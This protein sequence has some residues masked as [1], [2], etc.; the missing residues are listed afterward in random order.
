MNTT[1]TFAQ[2]WH[3]ITSE[4]SDTQSFWLSLFRDVLYIPFPEQYIQ[5]EKRVELSHMS[6]IDAYI[7]ST[8]III[9]QKSPGVNL[10]ESYSQ[11]DGT[12]MTPYEQA[13]RY[14]DWLPASEKGRY[15]I[16]CNFSE[17]RI[18][19]ME[20][21]KAPPRIIP[22]QDIERERSSL[23][24]IVRPERD[25]THEVEVSL[26][27]GE[28]AGKLYDEL[29]K[30]YVHPDD[31][32][33]MRS[34]N[35]LCVRI[36]FLLYAEDSGLFD[37]LQFHDYLKAR[38][39]TARQSLI[40]LFRVLATDTT[41]R[42]PYIDATLNAFPYVNG[43]LFEEENIE[44]PLLDGEPLRIILEEMS[45]GFDW[46]GISP[47]IFG[48]V[49]ESTLNPETRKDNGMHYT[50]IE[51]IHRV[52]D[53]MF[54]Y[55]YTEKAES[56]LS[57]PPSQQRNKD[58]RKL[59]KEIASLKFFD[60][61]CGSGNFL[62]ETYLSLRRLENKII[63][64]LTKGQVSFAFSQNETPVQV[65]IAQFYGIEI[66]DFAVSVART[67][68]WIAETQ[69]LNETKNIVQVYEDILPLK[70]H[71]TIIEANAL[72][73]DWHTITTP[74]E[75]LYIISNPPFIGHQ[76][77]K[78]YQIEDMKAAFSGVPEYGKFD[79]VCA[80]YNRAADF[81]KGTGARAAFV[82]TNSICQ[83]ELVNSFWKFM[84]DKGVEIFFAY[85][86]FVWVSE[87]KDKAHV[88]C[89][90]VGISDAD[91]SPKYIY[92]SSGD[93]VTRTEAK[94]INGWLLDLDDVFL[95]N[96]GA[97]MLQGMPRMKKGS[98]PTDGGNLILSPDERAELLANYPEA[99]SFVRRYM[100]GKDFLHDL[101]RYCLW[102]VDVEPGKFRHIKPIMDRLALV[103]EK[104]RKSSTK[105]VRKAADTPY[106]F[107]QV[108]QPT[109]D[110]FLVVPETTSSRRQYIPMGYMSPDVIISNAIYILPDTDLYMFGVLMSRI[111][112]AWVD[113]VA[114]RL[115]M[116][117]TYSPFVYNNYPW[118][119][120]TEKQRVKIER[121]AQ[122]IL[123]ERVKC[124]ESTL[125]DMYEPLSMP[126]GLR[127]AHRENDRAVFRAYGWD[128]EISDEEIVKRLFVMYKAVKEGR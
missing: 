16:V 102:L 118:P 89:V 53:P 51:N 25:Y 57:L 121:C 122:R 48:A 42:D 13:K 87:A 60:P 101:E 63:A 106:M 59:Q 68:L 123:D 85:R 73:T 72:R 61:A 12:S 94:H 3:N 10:D 84:K 80:W 71:S 112:M 41:K 54:M 111:H 11:S 116:D 44:I 110:N 46:S 95:E 115:R 66:N 91:I 126:L 39:Q 56:L 108:R 1:N 2:R 50:S 40:E 96:R 104:R 58:L 67:A 38:A 33:S 26:R 107:E 5:F 43:G 125:A 30:R 49:F 114:G 27:A 14:Y 35:I 97:P 76:W 99:E 37:K 124:P 128:E 64:A 45:E 15:I 100:S 17:L 74:D 65:S 19:D 28:L 92:R 109:N 77:R 9:E 36:V 93:N 120:A 32:E 62:T 29:E 81:M 79:Y 20:Q 6:F 70:T 4:K 31:P 22:L 75:K 113:V 78:K 69:M 24:F 7:P 55:E 47:T 127:Q 86:P 119:C 21:P 34:L 52:I 98:Q 23:A 103:A 82:S 117:Y 18:H 8:G 88:H 105:A 90:V 83:G